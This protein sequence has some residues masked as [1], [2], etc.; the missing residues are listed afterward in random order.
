MN[1]EKNNGAKIIL[2]TSSCSRV[3]DIKKYWLKT[4]CPLIQFDDY[5]SA[6]SDINKTEI[7]L[8]YENTITYI[9]QI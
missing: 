5:I 1:N 3:F 6:S 9:F 7:M 4:N 2:L 8:S